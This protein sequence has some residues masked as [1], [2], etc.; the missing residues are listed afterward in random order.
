M[1]KRFIFEKLNDK[2]SLKGDFK[3][4]FESIKEL[5]LNR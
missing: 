4:S 1:S 5:I 2:N 3:K